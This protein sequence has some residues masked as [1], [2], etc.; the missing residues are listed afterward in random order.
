MLLLIKY[1]PPT[2]NERN[3]L[4][5]IGRKNTKYHF[6]GFFVNLS[7]QNILGILLIKRNYMDINLFLNILFYS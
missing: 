4:L 7:L 6:L 1:G 5:V 2:N 3:I